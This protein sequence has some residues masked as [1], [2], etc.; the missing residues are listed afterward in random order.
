ME[1]KLH[2]AIV[3]SSL[4]ENCQ[5]QMWKGIE[6]YCNTHRIETTLFIGTVQGHLGTF[7]CHY[8]VIFDLIKSSSCFDGYLIFAGSVAD[9]ESP[10]KAIEYCHSVTQ[11]PVVSLSMR[12]PGVSS[13]C[14]EN[15]SGI[16]AM[17][18]HLYEQH[19]KRKFVCITGPSTHPEAMERLSAYKDTLLELGIPSQE[20]RIIPGSFSK[21]SGHHAIASLL[22]QNISFDAVVCADDFTALGAIEELYYQGF[23]VPH[24][25][26]VTGFD[27]IALS[28]LVSPSIS[29]VTQ[30]F[31]EIGSLGAQQLHSEIISDAAPHNYLIPCTLT[32]RQS[33]GCI[34]HGTT[35][36]T[37]SPPASSL[38]LLFAEHHLD[39]STVHEWYETLR[40]AFHPDRHHSFIFLLSKYLIEYDQISHNY[41]PWYTLFRL[42]SQEIPS[43]AAEYFEQERLHTL[44]FDA[45]MI[46]K[47]MELNNKQRTI[48]EQNTRQWEI[49]IATHEILTSF[50]TEDFY[51]KLGKTFDELQ[52]PG[53]ILGLYETPIRH[54]DEWRPPE[55]I[56]LPWEY[57][58]TREYSPIP[59]PRIAF[60][61]FFETVQNTD[62]GK[63]VHRLTLPLFHGQEQFGILLIP[64][65]KHHPINVYE[66]LRIS[67]STAL[68]ETHMIE[69]IHELAVKDSLTS[70]YNRRGFFNLVE[71]HLLRIQ[72][73]KSTAA[74]L[75]LDMD[76][77]K[78]IN[79]TL[80]HEQ[81]DAAICNLAQVLR[82]SIRDADILGRY[83]GDEFVLFLH[84]TKGAK[85]VRKRIQH[86]LDTFSQ[87]HD[88]PYTI[89]CSIGILPITEENAHNCLA[90]LIS[91]ADALQYAEKQAKKIR[92]RCE[93]LI[94][95]QQ[96]RLFLYVI[97]TFPRRERTLSERSEAAP[98]LLGKIPRGGQQ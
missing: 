63:Y 18:Q 28:G 41:A 76:N 23:T 39:T 4:E 98:P 77:L 9:G 6:S 87:T 92:R 12:V 89:S 47:N 91:E 48:E 90:D 22:K 97:D 57:P 19:G 31:L 78:V 13:V 32:L 2:F 49:R 26:A 81:G 73:D 62:V 29:T 33:C 85:E 68:Q 83:G 43:V 52:I 61:S 8:D 72:R 88:T 70:L 60:S 17:I 34:F 50:G 42:L 79:D 16:R 66:T 37:P 84:T 56:T 69:E 65:Q 95:Q 20:E 53:A 55:Y 7:E 75:F 59:A 96:L 30:P 71:A 44:L 40:H 67:I 15:R 35:D 82:R 58:H 94:Q 46:V 64:Y 10:Q 93:I 38:N 5:H 21:K 45:L 54:G 36:Q 3:V 1:K 80:G 14:V 24:D 11:K 86:E 25:I 27:D 51:Q 74:L